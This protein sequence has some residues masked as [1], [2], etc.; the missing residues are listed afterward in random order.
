MAVGGR[1]SVPVSL[2]TLY[3]HPLRHPRAI[4]VPRLNIVYHVTCLIWPERRDAHLRPWD[5]TT[6]VLEERDHEIRRPFA[7]VLFH[8]A[9]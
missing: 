7:A 4:L 6:R 3:R 5:D 9:E 8:P 2:L 1:G